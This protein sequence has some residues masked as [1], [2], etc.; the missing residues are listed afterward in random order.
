[1]KRHRALR[2]LIAHD[3][4]DLGDD[5]PS[6]LHEHHVADAQVEVV[7]EV[8]IVQRGVRDGRAGQTHRLNDRLRRE[9]TRAADLHDNVAHT[10]LLLLRRILI[11][12]RPARELCRAAEILPLCK[13]VD[14]D[15]RTVNVERERLAV[16]ADPVNARTAGIE[17]FTAPVRHNREAQ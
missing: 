11:C 17:R 4:E 5:L 16:V 15:D 9:H 7:D 8:L 12:H 10:A 1:M 2:P 6:L 3:G 13:V 14:L